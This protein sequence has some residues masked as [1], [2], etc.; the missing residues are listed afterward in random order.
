[1]VLDGQGRI[2]R[3]NRA[4]ERTTGFSFDEARGR[5]LW[6]LFLVPEEVEPVKA[7]FDEL[8]A[9]QFPNEYENYW[10]TKDGGCRLIAWS[11]TALLGADGAVEYVIGTGI[12]ITERKQAEEAVRM[13][14]DELDLR[15]LDRTAELEQANESLQAEIAER[16]RVEEAL[17][18]SESHLCSLM[19]SAQ[20]YAIYRIAFDPSH[21]YLAKVVLTSPSLNE[22]LGTPDLYDLASWL[23]NIHPD[24]LPRIVEANRHSLETGVPFDEQFRVFRPERGDWRWVHDRST[25]VFDSAGRLTH[26][27]GLMVDIT[28][29][30]RAEDEMR[31]QNEYLAAL[32]ETTLGVVSRLEPTD[33]LEATVERAVDLVGATYGFA[34]LVRP[35]TDEIEV[36]VGTGPYRQYVGRR[37][38][39]GEGLS[40]IIWQSGQPLASVQYFIPTVAG[41]LKHLRRFQG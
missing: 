39:R 29:Q 14:H 5:L 41:M 3:F 26:F 19:E 7:V 38:R 30:K 9:G 37:L 21:P 16:R 28:E 12:D 15:V 23:T 31:R 34:Y 8:R 33:L 35:G 25:P 6:E 36:S 1:V 11:N 20:H 13:A 2:V 24:D 10:V 27:N 18:E 4:C 40:G 22:L 17:R 32:H